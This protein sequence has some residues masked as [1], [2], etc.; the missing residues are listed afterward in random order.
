MNVVEL[1]DF[2]L[3]SETKKL[4]INYVISLHIYKEFRPQLNRFYIESE[5]DCKYI[6]LK[7]LKV[8]F[9]K[10]IFLCLTY[11]PEFFSDFEEVDYIDCV[12]LVKIN[13]GYDRSD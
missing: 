9:K 1:K 6:F 2:L 11:I 12:K 13:D 10:S 4:N 3:N 5:K 7:S 8:E